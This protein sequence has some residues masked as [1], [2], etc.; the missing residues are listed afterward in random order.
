MAKHGRGIVE[1]NLLKRR[2]REIGRRRVLPELGARGVVSDVLIR[3][4][5]KAYDTRFEDLA[6]EVLGAVEAMWSQSS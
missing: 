6:G 4:R 2:L 3:A 1:R 5:G